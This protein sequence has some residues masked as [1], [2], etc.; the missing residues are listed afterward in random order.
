LFIQNVV[1]VLPKEVIA[2][3][4]LEFVLISQLGIT[5]NFAKVRLVKS[6]LERSCSVSF[7][8][9]SV[10]KKLSRVVLKEYSV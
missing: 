2:L 1:E 5:L 9:C 6:F 8:L 4:V 10:Q 3:E 7:L